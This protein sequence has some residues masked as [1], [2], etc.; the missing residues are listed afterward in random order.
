MHA[1]AAAGANP[2]GPTKAEITTPA[3]AI[4]APN[5]TTSLSIFMAAQASAFVKAS[6]A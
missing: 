3:I 2:P 4:T 6:S 5:P 1:P